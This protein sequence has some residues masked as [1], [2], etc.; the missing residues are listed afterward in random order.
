MSE[1]E[2]SQKFVDVL[3]SNLLMFQDK[4]QATESS[5]A[6]CCIDPFCAEWSWYTNEQKLI[7]LKFLAAHTGVAVEKIVLDC[8]LYCREDL[9]KDIS[10]M[11]V[12]LA[13]GSLLDYT[14]G[15]YPTN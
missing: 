8:F 13:L 1:P 4:A 14:L 6:R 15:K 5:L 7:G 2:D 3:K 11:D 10:E 9:A 12:I